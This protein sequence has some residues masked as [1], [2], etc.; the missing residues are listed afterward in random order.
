M[1]TKPIDQIIEVVSK[2]ENKEFHRRLTITLQR[3]IHKIQLDV[4]DTKKKSDGYCVTFVIPE[5]DIY[6]L[7]DELG[8]TKEEIN[9]AFSTQWVV[10]STARMHFIYN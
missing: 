1:A 2:S 5:R 7:F 6:H 4:L 10:P 8:I 9:T 3:L